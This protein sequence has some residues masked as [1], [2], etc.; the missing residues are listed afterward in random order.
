MS[1]NILII[2]LWDGKGITG[3]IIC[4]IRETEKCNGNRTI[5]N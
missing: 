5:C 3:G 2:I 1:S 4:W